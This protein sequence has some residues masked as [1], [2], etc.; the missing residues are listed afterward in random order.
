MDMSDA[1][2]ARL[3]VALLLVTP[4]HQG[5][6]VRSPLLPAPIALQLTVTN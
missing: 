2:D 4:T 3:P 5:A 1:V 6:A